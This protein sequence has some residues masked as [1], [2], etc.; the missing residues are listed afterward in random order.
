MTA[1]VKATSRTFPDT[2]V[3]ALKTVAKFCAAALAVS[4]LAATLAATYG[5][6]LSPGFF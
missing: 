5:L 1:I 2:R 6:D 3:D 4:L